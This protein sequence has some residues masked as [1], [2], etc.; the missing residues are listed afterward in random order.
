[1][2]S[3]ARRQKD[4]RA[5]NAWEVMWGGASSST[6]DRIT[7]ES[8]RKFQI[9]APHELSLAKVTSSRDSDTHHLFSLRLYCGEPTSANAL[10]TKPLL[11]LLLTLLMPLLTLL[12]TLLMLL[13]TLLT[14]LLTLLILLLT[15]LTLLLTL[16]TLLL[17]FLLT[18]LLTLPTLLLVLLSV[19]VSHPGSLCGCTPAL[20]CCHPPS[21]SPRSSSRSALLYGQECYCSLHITRRS[22]RSPSQPLSAGCTAESGS[23][24]AT[25]AHH[26]PSPP[27]SVVV[28]RR[29]SPLTSLLFPLP[30]PS[31]PPPPSRRYPPQHQRLIL[32]S[33]GPPVLFAVVLAESL[34][35]SL[36]PLLALLLMFL[37]PLFSIDSF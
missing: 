9:H 1:M 19:D 33:V 37:A 6:L 15:L 30:L 31:L 23:P 3:N 7:F 18:L 16:L 4:S 12:L 14:L 5:Y 24:D 28:L 8:V 10:I 11:T 22:P 21:C 34:P 27:L 29:V 20:Q 32:H 17:T 26:S 25:A 2:A 35:S 13:L 36:P